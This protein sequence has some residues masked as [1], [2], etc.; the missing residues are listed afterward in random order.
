MGSSSISRTSNRILIKKL[1]GAEESQVGGVGISDDIA[2]KPEE[3][4]IIA[5]VN[6]TN[7]F[8]Q[9]NVGTP[10]IVRNQSVF[11]HDTKLGDIPSNSQYTIRNG[12]R[13]IVY[14]IEGIRSLPH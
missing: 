2:K 12:L 5:L 7:A 10:V 6:V 1:S 3:Q 8:A 9:Q 11:T 13:G 4:I 14:N